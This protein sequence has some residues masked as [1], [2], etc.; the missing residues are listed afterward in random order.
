MPTAVEKPSQFPVTLKQASQGAGIA[1]GYSPYNPAIPGGDMLMNSLTDNKTFNRPEKIIEG[2]YWALRSSELRIG[3]TA[4]LNFL[5]RELVV[6]RGEDRS[7]E[8]TSELQSL[9]HL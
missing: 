3:R 7:E 9:R 1:P 5:G 2:W 4:P 8:H 6:Y